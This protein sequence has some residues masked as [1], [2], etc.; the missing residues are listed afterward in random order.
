VQSDAGQVDLVAASI[1][2]ATRPPTDR[3]DATMSP[4]WSLSLDIGE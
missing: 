3:P 1:S 4:N 2:A